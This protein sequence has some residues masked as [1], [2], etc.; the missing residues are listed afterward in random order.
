MYT[1]HFEIKKRLNRFDTFPIDSVN[2][3]I[4]NKKSELVKIF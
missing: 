4:L 1:F 2:T 3:E